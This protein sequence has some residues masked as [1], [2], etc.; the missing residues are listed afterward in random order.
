MSEA[1]K[2]DGQ[3]LLTGLQQAGERSRARAAR[4][5]EPQVPAPTAAAP[6]SI[7]QL[8]REGTIVDTVAQ[9]ARHASDPRMSPERAQLLEQSMQVVI[10]AYEAQVRAWL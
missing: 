8:R 3:A 4:E 6:S 5:P 2:I 10:N 7:G 1:A 9:I